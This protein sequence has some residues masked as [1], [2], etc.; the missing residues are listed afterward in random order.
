LDDL[1]AL[2]PEE[3]AALG[4]ANRALAEAYSWTA[5]VDRMEEI[6]AQVIRS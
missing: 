2:A 4:A 1:L 6:Y 3:R 5:A